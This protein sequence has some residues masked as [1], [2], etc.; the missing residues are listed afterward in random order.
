MDPNKEGLA[1][2]SND[3]F[4]FGGWFYNQDRTIE[5]NQVGAIEMNGQNSAGAGMSIPFSNGENGDTA[6]RP[7]SN[8]APP[9]NPTP[10]N[11]V[12]A[13]IGNASG[14][15]ENGNVVRLSAWF[16]ND[17]LDPVTAEP[18]IRPVL[19]FEF[20]RIALATGG[21]MPA[22]QVAL[23]TDVNLGTGT[24]VGVG[25]LSTNNWTL[26]S[27]EYA[28]NDAQFT[29]GATVGQIE[30]I[31][32][33]IFAGDFDN[34]GSPSTGTYLVDNV[35]VE[36]FANQAAANAS[37]AS[38]TNPRPIPEPSTM[39]MLGLAMVAAIGVQRR[40]CQPGQ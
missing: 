24:F 18:Q 23:D 14:K 3:A 33:V 12:F 2:G 40:R 20:H 8:G 30:E 16:R 17:P 10:P 35:L 39:A 1:F 36:I 26:F 37:P 22:Q 6:N 11:P 5:G 15:L 19:K 13:S 7:P 27:H 38:L 21:T 9:S 4:D 32:P 34:N 31:R 28:V 29:G 25:S